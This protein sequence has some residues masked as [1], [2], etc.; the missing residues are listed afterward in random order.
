MSTKYLFESKHF[1]VYS[2]YE[3]V[4]LTHKLSSK[5]SSDNDLLIASHYGDPN[6]AI[7]FPD[8]K[9]VV[10]S[11]CGLSIYNVELQSEIHILDA[12]NRIWWT[13]GL[14]QEG[15]DNQSKEV[16]FVSWNNQSHLRIF[17]IDVETLEIT[18]M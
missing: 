13:N 3:N 5:N 7:I 9:Y 8:E 18:E 15:E 1:K 6:G 11:G 17:K 12:P 16:R 4:Y 14:H 10:V 2:C